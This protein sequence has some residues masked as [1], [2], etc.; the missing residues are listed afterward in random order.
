MVPLKLLFYC[1]HSTSCLI[2]NFFFLIRYLLGRC[3]FKQ[4]SIYFSSYSVPFRLDDQMTLQAN[5][6][7]SDLPSIIMLDIMIN[8]L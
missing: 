3:V 8:F 5:S 7:S 1:N 6:S 2:C 4:G